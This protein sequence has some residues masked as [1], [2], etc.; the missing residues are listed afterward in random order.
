MVIRQ[1]AVQGTFMLLV[2]LGIVWGYSGCNKD[3]PA[4]APYIPGDVTLSQ[5]S[6]EDSVYVPLVSW[7]GG[8]V[9][10]LGVNQ[11]SISRIDSSLLWLI[12][13]SG[14]AL[15]YQQRFGQTPGGAQDLTTQYGGHPV[16]ALQ[17]DRVYTFW[18]AKDDAWTAI[19]AHPGW[20]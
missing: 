9:G 4:L 14:N 6:V 10:A 17:E 13:E 1:K 20:V 12:H 19:A 7:V 3:T 18:V 15:H 8:Y 16:S 5:I 11:G 2:L